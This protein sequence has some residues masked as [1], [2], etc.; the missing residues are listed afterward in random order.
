MLFGYVTVIPPRFVSCSVIH[1]LISTFLLFSYNSN[2]DCLHVCARVDV[3]LIFFLL[4]ETVA[5]NTDCSKPLIWISG[6]L[7]TSFS[8]P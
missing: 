3:Y 5:G 1:G 6:L 4:T 8:D 2:D 7:L